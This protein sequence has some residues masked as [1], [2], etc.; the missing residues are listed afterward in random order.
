MFMTQSHTEEL[1]GQPFG[2]VQFWSRV[3]LSKEDLWFYVSTVH[4]CVGS[5]RRRYYLLTEAAD[6]QALIGDTSEFFWIERVMA[7]IPPQINGPRCWKMYQLKEL[8]AVADSTE[9]MPIDFIYRLENGL[10]YVTSGV[11]GDSTDKLRQVL[12][13][14][15]LHAHPEDIDH[16]TD[17]VG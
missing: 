6:L 14:E 16:K 8:I 13:S 17:L 15:K 1:I 5:K 7:V 3:E 11:V 10:S 2:K 12:F 9:L 4:S